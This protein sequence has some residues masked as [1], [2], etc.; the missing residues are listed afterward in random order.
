MS[1]YKKKDGIPDRW[2]DY[3]AVG[4]RLHGTRFISFKVPLKQSLNLKVPR[5]EVFGPWDLRDA[6][7][8]ENQELGLIID[9]TFTRRY[10]TPEDIPQSLLYVKIFT[11][12]HEIPS[13]ETILSFKRAVHRFLLENKG[14]DKLIGVHC[15]H[16]VNRTGYLICRYL[17]DVEGMDP[18]KAVELFNLSRGHAI[19]RQNYLEDLK[20]GPKRSNKD[21]ATHEQV[22][23]RGSLAAD[24][25]SRFN[26]SE[27]HRFEEV[28]G[29]NSKSRAP[30]D[31]KAKLSGRTDETGN[32]WK[33]RHEENPD[34]A[35]GEPRRG[36]RR[37]RTGLRE[38][39]IKETGSLETRESWSVPSRGSNYH[40]SDCGFSPRPPFLPQP[41]FHPPPLA[42]PYR[43]PNGSD[44][45]WRRPPSS[46]Q[47]WCA[48]GP[49]LERY[50]SGPQHKDRGRAAPF[51]LPRYSPRW[52]SIP[53]SDEA[54]VSGSWPKMRHP[55]RHTQRHDVNGYGN[56]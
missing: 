27:H 9:L 2:L 7:N 6:L 13:D 55:V 25:R 34:E 44:T 38:T 56:I 39:R 37:T 31:E 23:V 11:A 45:S 53:N 36:T 3:K 28:R 5:S 29:F 43:W 21:M 18:E 24:S 50:P 32:W 10:Y 40:Y 15:T 48:D 4:K 47:S 26:D 22:P 20:H 1:K 46:G 17:I 14:N 12:G 19:E 41:S 52:A 33:A 8:K 49:Y 30:E 35:R 54:A 42:Q 51:G 16:G